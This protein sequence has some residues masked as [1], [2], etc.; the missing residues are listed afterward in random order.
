VLP[1]S[2]RSVYLDAVFRDMMCSTIEMVALRHAAIEP[3]LA[4]AIIA[5][6][7]TK[8]LRSTSVNLNGSSWNRV[9]EFR[10]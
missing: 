3:H 2:A 6:A 4:V 8:L 9:G 5:D 7:R 1:N 10:V